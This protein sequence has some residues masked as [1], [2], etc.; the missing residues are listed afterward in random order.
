MWKKKRMIKGMKRMIKECTW[1]PMSFRRSWSLY[2]GPWSFW[3]DLNY[4]CAD[5]VLWTCH[6]VH[7]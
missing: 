4:K 1:G 5:V 7:S 2:Q 6:T 3:S